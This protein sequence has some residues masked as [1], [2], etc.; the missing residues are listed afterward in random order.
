MGTCAETGFYGFRDA[1]G[2]MAAA[3]GVIDGLFDGLD[4][5]KSYIIIDHPTDIPTTQQIEK[6]MEDQMKGSRPRMPQDLG[7]TLKLLDPEAMLP[8]CR[9]GPVFRHVA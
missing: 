8:D 7:M 6:R 9:R 4:A 2:R 3:D 5:G 1:E